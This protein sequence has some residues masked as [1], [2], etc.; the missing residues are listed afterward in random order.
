M[1]YLLPL[2]FIA[3]ASPTEYRRGTFTPPPPAPVR[4]GVGAPVVGHPGMQPRTIPRGPDR[5][6]LPPTRGP[7]IWASGEAPKADAVPIIG[8]VVLP[9]PWGEKPDDGLWCARQLDAMVYPVGM[10]PT[11]RWRDEL[12]EKQ[13]QCVAG[14]VYT[15][16][17]SRLREHYAK[18]LQDGLP[19]RLKTMRALLNEAQRFAGRKCRDPDSW[20]RICDAFW[21][22]L[23]GGM[24][25]LKELQ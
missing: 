5:R 6:V 8:G 25:A 18:T 9:L 10:T 16:C 17:L 11:N 7:G 19:E 20:S 24:D 22:H 13:R 2:L 4:I 1:R 12:T 14:R 3:C 23:L 21:W 15:E